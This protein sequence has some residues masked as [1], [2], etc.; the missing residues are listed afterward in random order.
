MDLQ[1]LKAVLLKPLDSLR[2]LG[3]VVLTDFTSLIE[4]WKIKFNESA[5]I[6]DP[7]IPT[8]T[9][10]QNQIDQYQIYPNP[11]IDEEVQMLKTNGKERYELINPASQSLWKGWKLHFKIFQTCP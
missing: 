7:A 9:N 5:C 1:Q 6:Y 10:D 3:E 4:E 11:F 2:N 8:S